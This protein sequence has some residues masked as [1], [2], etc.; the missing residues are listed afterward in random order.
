MYAVKHTQL[1]ANQSVAVYKNNI[2][3]GP[4]STVQNNKKAVHDPFKNHCIKPYIV[5]MLLKLNFYEAKLKTLIGG[6]VPGTV[7]SPD[8]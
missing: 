2:I 3:R 8:L 5:L 6:F 7:H 4:Q 1:L